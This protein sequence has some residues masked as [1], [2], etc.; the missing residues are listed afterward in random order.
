MVDF[1]AVL[2]LLVL[3]DVFFDVFWLCSVFFLAA[4]HFWQ[5]TISTFLKDFRQKMLLYWKRNMTRT[6]QNNPQNWKCMREGGRHDN[7]L[8]KP[9]NRQTSSSQGSSLKTW[10]IFVLVCSCVYI[11]LLAPLNT[12]YMLF[13][14]FWG[15]GWGVHTFFCDVTCKLGGGHLQIR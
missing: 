10:R 1:V 7:R 13:F 12:S 9:M 5:K 15:G 2:L 3:S 8:P 4:V 14:F 11:C 6:L